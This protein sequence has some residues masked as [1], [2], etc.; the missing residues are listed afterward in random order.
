M[1]LAACLGSAI[2]S[3]RA[4]RSSTRRL[5]PLA[6]RSHSPDDDAQELMVADGTRANEPRS[7]FMRLARTGFLWRARVVC[8]PP[9][10][11]DSSFISET[12]QPLACRGTGA[13]LLAYLWRRCG[14]P[15]TPRGGLA[16]ARAPL[17]SKRTHA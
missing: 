11:P 6:A 10:A 14:S 12:W 16:F 13:L 4:L 5:K 7:A 1:R 17:R 3:L 2:R 9:I 15:G 8:L